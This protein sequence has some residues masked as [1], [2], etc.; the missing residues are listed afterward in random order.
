V[1]AA[2]LA[3]GW[4][5]ARHVAA[6]GVDLV[7]DESAIVSATPDAWST[8]HV[9][10]GGRSLAHLDRGLRF[11]RSAGD[12][13]AFSRALE[14]GDAAR[15]LVFRFNIALSGQQAAQAPAMTFR[16]GAGFAPN[17]QDDG[18]AGTFARLGVNTLAD[19]SWQLRDLIASANSA[20]FRGTQAVTW[21]MNRSKTPLAYAAPDGSPRTV[22]PTRMDVWVGRTLVF[23]GVAVSVSTAPMTDLKWVWHAGTGTAA[24]DHFEVATLPEETSGLS[25]SAVVNAAPVETA[26]QTPASGGGDKTVQLYRPTPNPFVHNTAFAY[27]IAGGAERVDI[28]VYDLAGRRVRGLVSGTQTAGTYE[29]RWDG[30][31]DHGEQ[32]SR[33][34]YF[35]RANVG[36]GTRV[37]RIVLLP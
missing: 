31:N 32:A 9:A 19:G 8:F 36:A 30:R 21:A 18:A 6:E 12:N 3:V 14:G 35:V 15:G 23:D 11:V 26:S 5:M 2:L 34:M 37:M 20:T 1:L 7:D 33:G 4:S 27:A 28:G 17:A 24:F 22:G 13:V 10:G 25:Q 29:A 16:V